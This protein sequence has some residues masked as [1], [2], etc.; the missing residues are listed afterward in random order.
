M[1]AIHQ[2]RRASRDAILHLQAVRDSLGETREALLAGGLADDDED[3][4]QVANA[5]ANLEYA[6]RYAA[7]AYG[8]LAVR[9]VECHPERS[10]E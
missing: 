4:R 1:S 5:L 2:A 7:S 10:P 8:L 6:I 9:Q 3:V